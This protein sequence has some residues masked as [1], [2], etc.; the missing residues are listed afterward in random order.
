MII[1][2][3]NRQVFSINY[4][5]CQQFG[6]SSRYGHRLASLSQDT[7]LFHVKFIFARNPMYDFPFLHKNQM[8]LDDITSPSFDPFLDFRKKDITRN[9]VF[10]GRV[11]ERVF[12]GQ[13]LQIAI[14]RFY[15]KTD[16]TMMST[17]ILKVELVLATLSSKIKKC[18]VVK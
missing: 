2:N 15:L 17:I 6:I 16:H 7:I 4:K 11:Y 8:L 14:K 3:Q 12:C 10:G 1:V 9:F 18:E 5:K 13:A